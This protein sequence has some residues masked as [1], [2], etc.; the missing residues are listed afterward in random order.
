MS[1]VSLSFLVDTMDKR[2]GGCAPNIAYTLALLGERPRLMATAGQDFER[3]PPLAR[4]RRRSTPRSCAGDRRQV[5]GVVLLQHRRR[6][7]IRSRRSTPARW[8]MPASCRSARSPDRGIVDHLAQRSGRDAP[9]CARSAGRSAFRSSGIPGS[10]ARGCRATSFATGSSAPRSSSATTTSSSCSVRRPVWTRPVSWRI[11]ARSLSR[12]ASTAVPSRRRV[13]GRT[14]RR[15]RLIGL[16]TRPG[17]G[18]AYR[19]GFL[20]GWRAALS[21]E[22][23]ARLGS[24][25]AAFALEHLGGQSHSYTWGSSARVTRGNSA[26]SLGL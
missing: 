14:Y 23:C 26:S 11:L 21:Y 1:R 7:A 18:D 16:S 15:L 9:V 6:R 13:A 8:R 22:T 24:V 10:S 19:G 2:R 25:A 20:K 5:H 17:V 12:G 4:C 3:L